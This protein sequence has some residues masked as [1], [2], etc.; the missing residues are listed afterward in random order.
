[1]DVSHNLVSISNDGRVCYWSL[2][3]LNK[4]YDSQ[5]LIIKHATN[6]NV[7]A[8]CIDFQTAKNEQQRLAIVGTEDGLAHSLNASKYLN[9]WFISNINVG[10]NADLIFFKSIFG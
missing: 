4:P 5:E 2:E 9:V 3:N 10:F 7:Y 8:S 1:M 6:R